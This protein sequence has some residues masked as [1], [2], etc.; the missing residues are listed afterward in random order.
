MENEE[1]DETVQNF[2][3]RYVILPKLLVSFQL[4]VHTNVLGIW[5]AIGRGG[6]T[7]DARFFIQFFLIIGLSTV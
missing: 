6:S 7:Y 2:H 1:K 4:R 3:G 5:F